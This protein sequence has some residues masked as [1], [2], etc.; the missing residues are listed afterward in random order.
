MSLLGVHTTDDSFGL[1]IELSV[2]GESATMTSGRAGALAFLVL[3]FLESTFSWTPRQQPRAM[4]QSSGRHSTPVDRHPTARGVFPMDKDGNYKLADFGNQKKIKEE[5]EDETGE[6][7]SPGYLD[8]L[9]PSAAASSPAAISSGDSGGSSASPTSSSSP[10]L[11]P[12]MRFPIDNDGHYRLADVPNQ[13][14]RKEGVKDAASSGIKS[15]GYLDGLSTPKPSRRAATSAGG[16]I[17]STEEENEDSHSSTS[18]SLS[19]SSGV[20]G[21]DNAKHN[22]KLMWNK[23]EYARHREVQS[24]KRYQIIAAEAWEGMAE[25]LEGAYPERFHFHKTTWGKFPDGTDNIEVGGY[26]PYNVIAGERVLFLAS[27]HN[28]DVTLSQFQVLVMLLQSF[29][30][31]LVVVLPFYPVGTM[32]RTVK[33]GQVATANTY[34]QMFSNLPSCGRPTRLIIYDL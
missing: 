14:K 15:S 4:P 28:N 22:Y 31:E 16:G 30:K 27:F 9:S 8:G 23:L 1:L 17:G 29:I 6:T 13:Q 25:Q 3:I 11:P 7:K 21:G 33:E 26:T 5:D 12:S 32:E 19:L 20:A 24:R 18:S 34:A 10:F 2:F